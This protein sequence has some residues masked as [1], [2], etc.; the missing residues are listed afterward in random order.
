M[1]VPAA[2][3]ALLLGF[4]QCPGARWEKNSPAATSLPPRLKSAP[5]RLIAANLVQ[6][7]EIAARPKS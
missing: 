3:T 1:K 5:L 7:N 2:K 4:W 6:V